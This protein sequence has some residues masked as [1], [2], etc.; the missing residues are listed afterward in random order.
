MS[1]AMLELSPLDLG[2]VEG[3]DDAL[4][5]AWQGVSKKLQAKFGDAVFRSWL[6]PMRF[7]GHSESQVKIS[8]PTRFMREW[9]NKNY[10][11]E[12]SKIWGAE[13]VSEGYELSL[14]IA[15]SSAQ[16]TNDLQ[17]NAKKAA[18]NIM[19]ATASFSPES[20]LEADLQASGALLD[21]RYTFENFVVGK[22]NE[23]AHAAA[24][25]VAESNG[26]ARRKPAISLWWSGAG[27]NPPDA[28]NRLAYKATQ[29]QPQSSLSFSGKIHVSIHP[30]PALQRGVG[31]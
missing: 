19:E 27:K 16:T 14:V 31:V 25:R 17:K 4:S 3:L 8:V 7:A 13:P 18:E 9:I 10:I 23:L 12:I 11:S 5:S 22:P 15:D 1:M 28:R 6:A 20:Q 26:D 29:P 30:R 24:R 2:K 21:P